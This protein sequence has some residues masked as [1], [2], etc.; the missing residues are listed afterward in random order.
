MG[1][2]ELIGRD[3][4]VIRV[5]ELPV[6]GDAADGR[7]ELAGLRVISHGD[8]EGGDVVAVAHATG[9]AALLGDL[10]L[11]LAG[12]RVHDGAKVDLRH[13]VG[14]I[15]GANGNPRRGRA[16]IT[17]GDGSAVDALEQESEAVAIL[18]VT[19]LEDLRQAKVSRC[20]RGVLGTVRVLEQDPAVVV[21]H[22]LAVDLRRNRQR[23]V[24]VVDDGDDHLV[25][26]VV[27]GN[28]RD[29]VPIG[30]DDLCH[31]ERVGLVCVLRAKDDVRQLC[32]ILGDA[33]CAPLG[34]RE[35]LVG[36]GEQG[37]CLVS[38]RS[39]S[40]V[41]G[42]CI[43]A[44]DGEGE[45]AHIHG[46]PGEDLAHG[47]TGIVGDLG[48]RVGVR[49]GRVIGNA[50]VRI[51]RGGRV[52]VGD[53]P[54]DEFAIVVNDSD[55]CGGDVAVPRD[56][57]TILGRG[58]LANAEDVLARL[59]EGHLAG[60][61][62][63]HVAVGLVLERHVRDDAVLGARDEVQGE[64][65]VIRTEHVAADKALLAL[66]DT[67]LS[68]RLGRI[69]VLERSLA[70][71]LALAL[72]SIRGGDLDEV[73]AVDGLVGH[74]HSRNPDRAVIRHAG[75]RI[76]GDLLGNLVL[77]GLAHV[78]AREGD[79]LEDHDAMRVV[80]ANELGRIGGHG[81]VAHRSQR[82]L[83]HLGL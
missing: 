59:G 21:A 57:G 81:G 46:A 11:V 65:E 63:D 20:D 15:V 3:A 25:R 70:V 18:P 66:D 83:E 27:I 68:E 23:T 4:R 80:V 1:A 60:L 62:V 44:R 22:D 76:G 82:E 64:V 14:G 73:L 5:D 45:H 42:S 9:V 7:L 50:L 69:G 48:G 16:V 67:G 53:V 72:A 49:E 75:A 35:A 71:A 2:H 28:A 33:A 56:T 32:H 10:V 13:P 74:G 43:L 29:L 78:L 24:K 77:V 51:D 47:K 31:L 41:L 38:R 52:V 37:I 6:T 19:A 26:V 36:I 40:A 79:S 12:L 34:V 55:G 30:G 17:H 8:A 61:K 39:N 58:V 54:K